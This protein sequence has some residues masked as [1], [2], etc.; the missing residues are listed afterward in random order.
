VWYIHGRVA[1]QSWDK[2][3]GTGPLKKIKAGGEARLTSAEKRTIVEW[4]D[5]GAHR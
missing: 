3:S 1:A 2:V 4:I 5:T